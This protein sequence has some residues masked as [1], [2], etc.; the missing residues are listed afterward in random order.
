MDV[1]FIFRHLFV[2]LQVCGSGNK[3]VMGTK[4]FEV[5]C[6]ARDDFRQRIFMKFGKV[7]RLTKGIV[8]QFPIQVHGDGLNPAMRQVA[9]I[10][11]SEFLREWFTQQFVNV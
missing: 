2:I 5:Q 3:P 11:R 6:V 9:K 1:P 8:R 4:L 10:V 7:I